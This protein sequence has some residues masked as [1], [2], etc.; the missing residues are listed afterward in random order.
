M[1]SGLLACCL[2]QLFDGEEIK[3]DLTHLRDYW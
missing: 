1:F 2:Q 3:V